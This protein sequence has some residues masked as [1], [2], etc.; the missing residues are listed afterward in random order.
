MVAPIVGIDNLDVINE[1]DIEYGGANYL[2]DPK[3]ILWMI[4]TK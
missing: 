3:V 2:S 4:L 1:I